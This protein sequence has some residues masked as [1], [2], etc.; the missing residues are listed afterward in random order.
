[1]SRDNLYQRLHGLPKQTKEQMVAETKQNREYV[2]SADFL[3]NSF[4]RSPRRAEYSNTFK[5]QT[6]GLFNPEMH[7][8]LADSLAGGASLMGSPRQLKSPSAMA[9]TGS[10]LGGTDAFLDPGTGRHTDLGHAPIDFDSVYKYSL[11]EFACRTLTSPITLKRGGSSAKAHPSAMATTNTGGG[12]FDARNSKG[13]P[14]ATTR[15]MEVSAF[16]VS[17]QGA[18]ELF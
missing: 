11:Q 2:S 13:Q 1:M 4:V 9:S 14:A 18:D 5:T 7:E 16:G 8:S 6:L 12:P 15:M 10:T 17:S 3:P